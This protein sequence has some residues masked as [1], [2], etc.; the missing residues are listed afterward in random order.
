[1]QTST[2]LVRNYGHQTAF[3]A[4][5]EHVYGDVTVLMHDELQP[6]PKTNRRDHPHPGL[7]FSHGA[8]RAHPCA[9]LKSSIRPEALEQINLAESMHEMSRR[10]ILS[11]AI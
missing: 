10:N 1:M 11:V 8:M 6:R 7:T 3:A 9:P 2:T 4:A 5:R